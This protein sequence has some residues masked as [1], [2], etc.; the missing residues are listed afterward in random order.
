M[1]ACVFLALGL[2]RGHPLA[3]QAVF[4][5]AKAA[6]QRGQHDS[7]YTL[8]QRAAE[9]EPNRAEVQYFLGGVACDKAQRSGGLGK[10][11]PARAC[12]AA[13]GRAVALEPD[14][15]DYLTALAQFLS[16]APGIVGGDRDSALRLAQRVQRGDDARGTQLMV[17]VLLRGGAHD[18]ARADSVAD[19]FERAHPSDR[20][21]QLAVAQLWYTTGHADRSEAVDE[22]LLEQDATDQVA[23]FGVARALVAQRR[24]PRRAIELLAQVIA[25]PRPTG[26]GVPTYI[27]GA[28]WWRM[29]QAFEQLG[30]LDSARAAFEQALRVNPQLVP[31][32]RSLDSLTRR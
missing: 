26:T 17:D 23:R 3:S 30:Q 10:W 13:F 11:G 16:Q 18:K 4:E 12:R 9:L 20:R 5:Q 28:P 14:N 19:A 32:R 7:A 8:A 31:A 6:E 24:E 29:G 22:R 27:E 15:L 25:A 2:M 1:R 21:A